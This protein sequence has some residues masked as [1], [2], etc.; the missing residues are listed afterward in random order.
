M[1]L[2][3]SLWPISYSKISRERWGLDDR[4]AADTSVGAIWLLLLWIMDWMKSS[5]CLRVSEML[6][7]QKSQHSCWYVWEAVLGGLYL[8]QWFDAVLRVVR[9]VV[10]ASDRVQMEIKDPKSR[11]QKSYSNISTSPCLYCSFGRRERSWKNFYYLCL[12]TR[13]TIGTGSGTNK[14]LA[15]EAA[16]LDAFAHEEK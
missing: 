10:F 16:A 15:Q 2:S 9:D 13:V 1:P 8:D 11:L 4:S 5:W 12:Y 7:A 6:E 3:G 14:K